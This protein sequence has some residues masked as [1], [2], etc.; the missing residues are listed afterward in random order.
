M[1]KSNSTFGKYSIIEEIARGAMGVVYKVRDPDLKRELALKVMIA[2]ENASEDLLKRFLREA[3]AAARINHPNVVAVHEV[4]NIGGQYFFTMDYIQG[5]SFDKILSGRW[6]P[7]DDVVKHVRDIALA[8]KTAHDM[9]IIHR[10]IK[11]ANIM[12]DVKNERAL[13]ADFGLAKE[14]D[15]NTMLSMTG[16]MMGSPAYMSPEQAKGMVHETDHRTDLYS[17]G[18]LLY[19]AATGEQPFSSETVV[20]TIRKTVYEDPVPPRKMA[21][22]EVS[23]DLENIILKCMEKEPENRY[24]NAKELANDL[25][26]YLEGHKVRAKAIPFIR[27]IHRKIKKHPALAAILAL[28]PFVAAALAIATWHI[29]L[30]PGKL[31]L[32]AEALKSPDVKRQ[33]GAVGNIAAWLKSKDL[34]SPDEK[35]RAAKLLTDYLRN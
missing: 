7:L 6:M 28:S 18:V 16:M 10:D 21:P 11:P 13:L 27:S 33:A 34:N 31:D 20:D 5:T 1:L 26:A 8:L 4:G 30:A 25:T 35:H 14:L 23:K 32:A 22:G 19:E 9:N 2:G 29:F 12:F 15:G 3:R 17:L 24:Q